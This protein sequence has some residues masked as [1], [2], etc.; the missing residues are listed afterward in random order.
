MKKYV[1][2]II[3]AWLAIV[4]AMVG[5]NEYTIRTGTE[6]LL[7]TEP[8]DPRDLLRG[9]YVILRYDISTI[10]AP[11]IKKEPGYGKDVYVI[12][13]EKDGYANYKRTSLTKPSGNEL[14]IKGKTTYTSGKSLRVRYGIESYFVPEGKGKEIERL[15]SDELSV[16][17]SI[18]RTGRAIIKDLV[19]HKEN[20]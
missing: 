15:D 11:S 20:K 9:D 13:E 5:Y 7:K 10:D 17:V 2:A 4:V 3:L 12:L 6:V 1:I 8:V 19:I 16:K 14:F 18:D